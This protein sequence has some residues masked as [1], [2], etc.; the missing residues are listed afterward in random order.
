VFADAQRASAMAADLQRRGVPARVVK[1]KDGNH[2]RVRLGP[3]P[4][5][6]DATRS[7]MH[8]RLGGLNTLI[9]QDNE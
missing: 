4:S 5:H 9:F 8:W 2:Y 1:S 3:F 7:L 6:A